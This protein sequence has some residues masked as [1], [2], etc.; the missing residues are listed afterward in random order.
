MDCSYHGPNGV[1]A[2][3]GAEFSLVARS[4][5][6][7]AKTMLHHRR[8]GGGFWFVAV[9]ARVVRLLQ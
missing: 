6:T 9:K 8:G 4:S 3:D 7:H 2:T 5:D 1:G